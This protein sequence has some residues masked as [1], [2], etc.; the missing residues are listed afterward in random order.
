M[1]T[2]WFADVVDV[3]T[4]RVVDRDLANDLGIEADQVRAPGV[5]LS[6]GADDM[7]QVDAIDL[8]DCAWVLGP[9]AVLD[10]LRSIADLP[11]ASVVD[12]ALW[13][14]LFGTLVEHTQGPTV[15]AYTI[16][17]PTVADAA[18]VRASHEEVTALRTAVPPAEWL[19]SGFGGP[20]GETF[21]LV[22]DGAI[23]A[24]ANLTDWADE[25]ADVGVL[26]HPRARGRGLAAVVGAAATRRAVR[27]CGRARWRAFETNRTS[28]GVARRL[29]FVEYGRG[30][31]VRLAT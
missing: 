20:V 1:S 12:S 13:T 5:H 11:P 30:L 6:Q 7:H 17:E 15:H 25:P 22:E 14:S 31:V 21:A 2:A 27:A 9:E 4:Q 10:T 23:C 19:E 16:D 28:R 3:R 29:G 8:G 26:V 24:A 18:V